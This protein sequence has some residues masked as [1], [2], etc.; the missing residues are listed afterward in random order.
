MPTASEAVRKPWHNKLVWVKIGADV[1][2]KSLGAVAIF[3]NWALMP[4]GDRAAED[5]LLSAGYIEHRFMW[6]RP[7]WSM[8]KPVDPK[9]MPSEKEASALAYLCDEWDHSY[10]LRDYREVL[11]DERKRIVEH[12]RTA[13]DQPV[14]MDRALK[15]YS[16]FERKLLG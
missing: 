10:D 5:Y 4:L 16:A 12:V 15:F 8:R 14:E 9:W 2:R 7:R 11:K 13:N 1:D 6:Y 3:F